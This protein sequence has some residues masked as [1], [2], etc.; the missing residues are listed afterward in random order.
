MIGFQFQPF[1]QV[2]RELQINRQ[3]S[4]LQNNLYMQAR[5]SVLTSRKSFNTKRENMGESSPFQCRK[6]LQ[7]VPTKAGRPVITKLTKKI[8]KLTRYVDIEILM[9]VLLFKILSRNI[10]NMASTLLSQYWLKRYQGWLDMLILR[11]WW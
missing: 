3:Y 11:Y 8:S 4:F 6:I 10:L 5:R 1:S 7:P 9:I 2:I